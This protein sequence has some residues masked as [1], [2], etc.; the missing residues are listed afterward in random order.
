MMNWNEV[1]TLN[2]DGLLYWSDEYL[3]KPK[4]FNISKNKHAGH[5]FKDKKRKTSYIIIRYQDKIYQA[6][7]IIWEMFNGVIPDGMQIDHEDGN[8]LNNSINNLR[9]V[10]LSDNLKN[11]SKYCNNTSGVAGVSWHKTHKKWVSYISN[12]GKRITLGYFTNLDDAIA[13]RKQAESTYG[14]HRNHGR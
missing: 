12:S 9:L 3:S 11:K 1:L 13:A 6:H 2:D 7:R 5:I 10:S 4:M 8:G 14:Y